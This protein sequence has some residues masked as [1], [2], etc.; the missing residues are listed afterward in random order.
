MLPSN[1]FCEVTEL[2]I[3]RIVL[4]P[5][6]FSNCVICTAKLTEELSCS[7][8]LIP[9]RHHWPLG[10][11][12]LNSSKRNLSHDHACIT[13]NPLLHSA[14]QRK[15]VWSFGLSLHLQIIRIIMI[16]KKKVKETR[17]NK[18]KKIKKNPSISLVSRE[19]IRNFFSVKGQ[20]VNIFSFADPRVSGLTVPN[21]VLWNE[22]SHR[23]H[24]R[25]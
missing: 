24:L 13:D 14:S 20:R 25:K 11:C 22:S 9:T 7:F 10:L 21:S 8:T 18:G 16:V 6:V 19:G 2:S 15:A 17:K 1:Y 3:K 5:G 12:S 4:Q 23:Q